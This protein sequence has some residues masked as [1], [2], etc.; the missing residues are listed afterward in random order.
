MH[1]LEHRIKWIEPIFDY[2]QS[3]LLEI[4]WQ[5]H[6]NQIS[7]RFI[8]YHKINE[9]KEIILCTNGL[10]QQFVTVLFNANQKGNKQ[11]ALL[12][13]FQLIFSHFIHFLC[14]QYSW[15]FFVRRFFLFFFFFCSLILNL[16]K[17]CGSIVQYN[18][19]NVNDF[20]S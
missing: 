2:F 10:M 17:F 4:E 12:N 1:K 16:D 9:S 5:V 6:R 13:Y 18:I 8:E 7:K 14:I 19:V 11:H 3:K 20:E 15:L